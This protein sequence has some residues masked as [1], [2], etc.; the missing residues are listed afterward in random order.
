MNGKVKMQIILLLHCCYFFQMLNDCVPFFLGGGV[1]SV[2]F[3]STITFVAIYYA[4]YM[5]KIRNI[6]KKCIG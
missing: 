5:C 2:F 3:F 4:S 1:Q 6:G